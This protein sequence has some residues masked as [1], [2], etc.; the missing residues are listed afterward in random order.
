MANKWVKC[1]LSITT[2]SLILVGTVCLIKKHLKHNADSFDNDELED[3]DF[4]LDNVST[5]GYVSL[6][7]NTTT[8]V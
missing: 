4:D 7:P 2:T 8:E 1:I 3:E 6:T 5:R